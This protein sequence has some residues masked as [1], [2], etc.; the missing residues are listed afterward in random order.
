MP[1]P[2]EISNRVLS[3]LLIVISPPF[4]VP[5]DA[6]FSVMTDNNDSDN[7]EKPTSLVISTNIF[8]VVAPVVTT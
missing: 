7:S 5:V 4:L 6:L 8:P 2:A 1:L 3:P